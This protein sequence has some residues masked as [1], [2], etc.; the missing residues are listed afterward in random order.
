[1][2][3]TSQKPRDVYIE[4]KTVFG[5]FCRLYDSGHRGGFRYES[6]YAR[7]CELGEI[8]ILATR[9]AASLKLKIA[10]YSLVNDLFAHDYLS[11]NEANFGVL[12][13]PKTQSDCT[14]LAT[15]CCAELEKLA[16]EPRAI[17]A[18]KRLIKSDPDK[19][20]QISCMVSTMVTHSQ[21]LP[22]PMST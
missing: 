22:R 21:M 13:I 7:A 3:T 15:E 20:C 14:R 12:P 16:L 11:R 19:E 10:E 9:L 8:C 2:S 18:L 1:M 5:Q 6:P 4:L 17:S